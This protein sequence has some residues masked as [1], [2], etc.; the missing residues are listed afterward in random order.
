MKK[1]K[2]QTANLLYRGKEALKKVL[3]ERGI[4]SI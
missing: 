2:R 3:I 1:N 4:E